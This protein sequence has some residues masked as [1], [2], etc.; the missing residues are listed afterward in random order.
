MK[1]PC[2]QC[3][4]RHMGYHGRCERYAKYKAEIEIVKQRRW[5]ESEVVD[6]I[7]EA[8]RRRFKPNKR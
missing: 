5:E 4:D 3:P 8:K 2:Y 6:A 7:M 1:Q